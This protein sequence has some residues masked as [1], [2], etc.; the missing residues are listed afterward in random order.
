MKGK[1]S[2]VLG[3]VCGNLYANPVQIARDL[4]GEEVNG[5]SVVEQINEYDA[6]WQNF[7]KGEVSYDD[8]LR[9]CLKTLLV[10][11][12]KYPD[13]VGWE[14]GAYDTALEPG[15]IIASIEVDLLQLL[16]CGDPTDLSKK[17]SKEQVKKQYR[18]IIEILR[19]K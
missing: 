8:A 17:V 5:C 1:V 19:D 15:A 7:N 3:L 4:K 14:C 2:F 16:Q 12:K 11:F 18:E 6:A 13:T 10:L 9:S